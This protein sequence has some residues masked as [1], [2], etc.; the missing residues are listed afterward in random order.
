MKEFDKHKE[1]LIRQVKDAF[2]NNLV[3]LLVYGSYVKGNFIEKRSDINLFMICRKINPDQLASLY[4]FIRHWRRK[5]NLA[6][7]LLLTESEVRNSTDIFPMEYLDIREFHQVLYGKDI[8]RNL[9]INDSFLR[10][11][12]ENQ[13]KSK[14]IFLRSSFMRSSRHP[15]YLKSVLFNTLATVH[16][17]LNNLI[18]LHHKKSS[19]SIDSLVLEAETIL[20]TPLTV[21]QKMIRLKQGRLRLKRNELVSLFKEFILEMEK[22]S[23]HVDKFKGKKK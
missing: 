1:T 11:E 14:L 23:E 7:P 4:R 2:G 13:V 16:V 12:L 9:R 8:F 15:R 22:L 19:D 10:L 5:I 21:L 6:L 18:K 17:I 20:K 3:S